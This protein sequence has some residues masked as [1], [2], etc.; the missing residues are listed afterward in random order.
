MAIISL[1]ITDPKETLEEGKSRERKDG[2]IRHSPRLIH[3]GNFCTCGWKKKIKVVYLKTVI[4]PFSSCL[5]W[6]DHHVE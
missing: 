2:K 1:Q 3:C 6:R 5:A 4:A